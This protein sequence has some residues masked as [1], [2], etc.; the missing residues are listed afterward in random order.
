M[1]S[2]SGTVTYKG[3]PINNGTIVFEVPGARPAT[4]KIVD[5]QITEVT[6]LE[7][8]DGVP[9]GMAK[10]SVTASDASEGSAEPTPGSTDPGAQTDLSNYMGMGA[11]SIIP[12]RYNDPASSGLSWEIEKGDNTVTL[13]LTE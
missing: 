1:G 10:I 3:E 11:E 8:G 13:D 4:G 5:G 12:S 6:T 2:V 9:V 7:K